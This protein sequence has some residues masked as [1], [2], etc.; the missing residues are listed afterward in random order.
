MTIWKLYNWAFKRQLTEADL[1]GTTGRIIARIE[2]FEG[3]KF[4]HALPAHALTDN[5]EEFFKDLD[6]ATIERFE[7]LFALLNAGV[8]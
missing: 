8:V 7:Q 6:P 4:N 5:Q 3:A 1:A 2:T